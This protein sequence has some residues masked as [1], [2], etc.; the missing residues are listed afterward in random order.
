ML[1]ERLDLYTVDLRKNK[2]E[3]EV[4]NDVINELAQAEA[5]WFRE[6]TEKSGSSEEKLKEQIEKLQRQ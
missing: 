3:V 4:Y 6:L 5:K 2:F 1:E